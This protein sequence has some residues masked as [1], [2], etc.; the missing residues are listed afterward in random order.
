MKRLILALALYCACV[1]LAQAQ[2]YNPPQMPA[3]A[4]TNPAVVRTNLELGANDSV[5]FAGIT[6]TGDTT[7]GDA[8]GDSMTVNAGTFTAPNATNT[9]SNNVANVGALDGRYAARNYTA[10][11]VANTIR[12]NNDIPTADP[13][14]AFSNVTVGVYK[15]TLF[16]FVYGNT[17]TGGFN[18]KIG[19]TAAMDAL[20]RS[21]NVPLIGSGATGFLSAP[22]SGEN[23]AAWAN[24]QKG[25]MVTFLLKI[26]SPGS[27]E[28]QWSQ[29]TAQTNA[30]QFYRGSFFTLDPL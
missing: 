2:I 23:V 6:N 25:S 17:N 24:S 8:A 29:S 20:W 15:V 5:T 1:S 18:W 4:S 13:E 22:L 26:T 30:V 28:F 12:S 27:V 10:F 9:S 7:L 16:F 21:V 14:L 11:K 3:W 19:G